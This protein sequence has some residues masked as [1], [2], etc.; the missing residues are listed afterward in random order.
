MPHPQRHQPLHRPSSSHLTDQ[1]QEESNISY[2]IATPE[3]PF[4][5]KTDLVSTLG[6]DGTILH[7]ASLFSTSREVPAVL[8]F[9]MGTLGFL[10]EYKWSEH[11][12]A[13]ELMQSFDDRV[14]EGW[15]LRHTWQQS[16]W[17][18]GEYE[19][20]VKIQG[21]KET[22]LAI[23]EVYVEGRFLTEAVAD[24][25]IIST[26]TGSTGYSLSSG[27]SMIHPAVSSLLLTPIC[28]RSLSFRPLVLPAD[29]LLSLSLADKNRGRG[30]EVS[31][32]GRQW[33]NMNTGMEIRV[34]GETLDPWAKGHGI[35]IAKGPTPELPPPP[36]LWATG[37]SE[38]Q[39]DSTTSDLTTRRYRPP[40]Q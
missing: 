26:P 22:H 1:S 18:V 10:G 4:H 25:L 30:L 32:D 24:R 33:V 2:A 12:Q 31:V 23:V 19:G 15:G 28:P 35:H 21:G 39:V 8:S 34:W 29:T 13:L 14:M 38:W 36:I 9:S 11:I 7:E 37:T 5:T 16:N 3:N 40:R 6:G 20:I 17:D 27:G